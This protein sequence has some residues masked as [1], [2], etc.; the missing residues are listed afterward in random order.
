MADTSA[1]DPQSVRD[2]VRQ[3]LDGAEFRQPERHWWSPIV[4]FFQ[5]PVGSIV[6]A[7]GWLIDRWPSGTPGVALAWIVAGLVAIAV[8]VFVFYLSR[9]V[10]RDAGSPVAYAPLTGAKSADELVAEA[11]AFEANGE[12]AEAIRCRYG[13]LVVHLSDAGVVKGR[14][15]RT[16]GEY[17]REFAESVPARAQEFG[18]A[19]TI[20][21]WVWYGDGRPQKVDVERFRALA[22]AASTADTFSKKTTDRALTS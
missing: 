21:E 11:E 14:P 13:A 5:D 15:G 3:I 7:V 22:E 12:W 16:T 10:T 4:D 1:P 19:T 17:V 20:F 9:S 8:V 18:D 6:D 2:A